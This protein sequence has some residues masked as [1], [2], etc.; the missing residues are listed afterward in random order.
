V[1]EQV[2][3]ETEETP[4]E[5]AEG[6][7]EETDEQEEVAEDAAKLKRALER[8]RAQLK[9]TRSDLAKTRKEAATGSDLGEHEKL[10][11]QV[12][13]LAASLTRTNAVAAL[14][15]AGFNGTKVQAERM[16]RLVDDFT[17][18]EWVEELKVDFPERFGRRTRQA[19]GSRP[20]T[21]HG[22]DESR[23]TAK[24]A[25]E[26]FADRLLGTSRRR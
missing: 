23:G 3:E 2:I 18:D 17:E 16:I 26:R 21:G 14:L 13:E 10:T 15:E 8:T 20:S 5:D 11:K 4:D 9:K 1:S 7:E 12:E 19:D 24:T 25:D 6:T 22:R